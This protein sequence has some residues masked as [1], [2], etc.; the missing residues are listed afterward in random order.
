MGDAFDAGYKFGYN[1]K[2]VSYSAFYKSFHL[3]FQPNYT[4]PD[5][6]D[7][8]Q[9][10]CYGVAD[11]RLA[12]YQH[13]PTS[14]CLPDPPPPPTAPPQPPVPPDAPPPPGDVPPPPPEPS[15]PPP[16][17]FCGYTI[18]TEPLMCALQS[19]AALVP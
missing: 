14:T 5:A 18:T 7:V 16:F 15:A 4:H 17:P 10:P 6:R 13:V 19:N 9:Y 3:S 2:G 12:C 1:K 8:E 11:F